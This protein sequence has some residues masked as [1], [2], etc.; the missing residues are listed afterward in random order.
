MLIASDVLVKE[1]KSVFYKSYYE[2]QY[3]PKHRDRSKDGGKAGS[4]LAA[5]RNHLLKHLHN[6]QQIIQKKKAMLQAILI[7][8]FAIDEIL[9]RNKAK[10][11]SKEK[12]VSFPFI[13]VSP[14]SVEVNDV[15]YH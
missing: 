13:M 6:K 15:N 11:I 2:N 8:V 14:T 10:P 1:N 4:E 12:V 7:K 3:K 5:K 9:K